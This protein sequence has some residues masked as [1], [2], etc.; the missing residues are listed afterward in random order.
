[1]E[2]HRGEN[3]RRAGAEAF[4]IKLYRGSLSGGFVRGGII[5]GGEF[6]GLGEAEQAGKEFLA[7]R[8]VS[9]ARFTAA[10]LSPHG[11]RRA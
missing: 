10:K 7:V 3:R 11:V 2:K 8:K 6:P 1:M 9:A 5:L 4:I